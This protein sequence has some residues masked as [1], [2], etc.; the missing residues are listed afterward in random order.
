MVLGPKR[1]NLGLVLPLQY[2]ARRVNQSSAPGQE[3]PQRA[4]QAG[5][6]HE[7]AVHVARPPQHFDVGVAADHARRAARRVDE[8]AI[9]RRAVPPRVRRRRICRD[10]LRGE[11]E[12]VEVLLHERD[13]R[14]V[15]VHGPDLATAADGFQDVTRL[16]AGR[17]ARIENPLA[18]LEL[19]QGGG[20]LRGDVLHG[21]RARSEP[22]QRLHPDRLR[23]KHSR[24]DVRRSSTGE[25][26]CRQL[27]EIIGTRRAREVHAQPQ[28]WRGVVSGDNR[29]PRL[30]V[31][32]A[33]CLDEPAR[34]RKPGLV[35]RERR[36]MELRALALKPSQHC[37]DETPGLAS[38]E[39]RSRI[40]RCGHGCVWRDPQ[41]LQLQQPDAQQRGERGLT[42]Y[43][44]PLEQSLRLPLEPVVPTQGAKDER[45]E[46]RLIASGDAWRRQ[47]AVGGDVVVHH[48][49]HQ[50]RRNGADFGTG[51]RF[52][53]QTPLRPANAPRDKPLRPSRGPTA[54]GC[55]ATAARRR[56]SRRLCRLALL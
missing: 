6:E 18:W 4:Q 2:G 47:Q 29:L 1:I 41:L 30:W 39:Q 10:D 35:D 27:V 13:A 14:G 46:Q 34:M 9:E 52:R 17:R 26:G 11:P 25:A 49:G 21:H 23:K 40:D 53:R 31:V 16:P 20:P 37:V 43:Q 55:A 28:W 24:T 19:E 51:R 15:A 48:P 22:G 50:S 33:Q 12:P 45:C 42:A 44:R 7:R 32:G 36:P 3:R 5:L 38:S 54:V 56:P 8:D